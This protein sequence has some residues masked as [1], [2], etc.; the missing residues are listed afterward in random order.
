M[1]LDQASK[2][3]EHPAEK[4]AQQAKLYVGYGVLLV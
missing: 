2:A 4:V 3:A 1:P